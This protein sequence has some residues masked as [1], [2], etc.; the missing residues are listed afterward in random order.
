MALRKSS[1][2][3]QQHGDEGLV[4]SLPGKLD[5]PRRDLRRQALGDQQGVVEAVADP[6]RQLGRG[7]PQRHPV[8]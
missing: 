7:Q 8:D 4:E 2:G 6:R 1:G 5:E 3:G